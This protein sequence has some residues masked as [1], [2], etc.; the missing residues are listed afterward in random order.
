MKF[1]CKLVISLMLF[2]TLSGFLC[3]KN[4]VTVKAA[5]AAEN[6]ISVVVD[7]EEVQFDVSPTIIEG[8]TM[9]PLRA[10][11]E[12]LEARVDWN[13]DTKTVTGI[14]DNITIKLVAGSKLAEVNGKQVLLDV[15]ATIISGRTL[16]P[17]RFISEG[18]GAKVS[19]DA[20]NREVT[21]LTQDVIK[22]PDVNFEKAIRQNINK[23]SGD[24]LSS[25]LKKILLFD[26]RE[27]DISDIEGIQ[28][29]KNARTLYLEGNSITDISLL[30]NLNKL[31][32]ISL[33]KNRISDI[34]PLAQLTNLKVI[35]IHTNLIRDITPLKSL[36]NLQELYIGGNSIKNIDV[37]SSLN[38]LEKL[39]LGDNQIADMKPLASLK[40]LTEIDIYANSTLDMTPL[41]EL[42]NLKEV[43]VEYY[44]EQ[45]MLNEEFYEKYDIMQKKARDIIDRVIKPGM[46]DLE[47]ELALHDYLVFNT[48][49][50]Y[51]NYLSDSVPEESH[52][53]Y[54][55]LINKVAVCDG[56]ART[57]QILLNMVGI[58]NEF[59]YGD[60]DGE[61]GWIGHAWNIVKVDGEYYHLDVTFD[62]IDR[63]GRDIKKDSITHT[64]FNVSDRQISIDHRWERDLYPHCNTDSD[65]FTR[66]SKM[67]GNKI[68]NQDTAY[69]LD[70][71]N[72]IVKL[73]LVDYTSSRLS[74]N[75]AEKVV[76]CED[77]IYYINMSYTR[78]GSLYR[79]KTDG[80]NEELVY[81][82]EV[83]FLEEDEGNIYF[84]DGDDRINI[85]SKSETGIRKIS[86]GSIATVLYFTEDFIIYKAYKW[87]I[88][89]HFYRISKDTGE[90]ERIN[91]DMPS[92]FSY[93]KYSGYLTYYNTPL[94]RVMDDW[95][96]YANTGEGNSLFK[97]K[98]DGTERSRLNHS[99]STIIDII[100]QWLYYH[101]ES[102]G[103]KV[104]RVKTDGSENIRVQE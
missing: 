18:F 101:N 50:D 2:F 60:A 44:Y 12:A 66:V 71:E 17:A 10:I 21:I 80:S 46:T 35:Y 102:D 73:N 32:R 87:D 92:G 55:V 51:E 100:G 13:P 65:Y 57:M 77:Y 1:N 62:N 5:P 98:V 103:S 37:L 49:Y 104:Y 99:D 7:W 26:A 38:K 28:Y 9:V 96:Y 29:M 64:Y 23:Y 25:D 79:V 41:K 15:P 84:I 45:T 56:F 3:S 63:D 85:I 76:L 14:R 48:T 59:I 24:I 81:N 4:L 40:M 47:K 36:I 61:K 70:G 54:G 6:H 91:S 82:G 39:Y 34:S 75:R 90:T 19:W 88:G 16:V 74:L 8:R 20:K 95:I 31:E 33:S 86:N 93:S 68:I 42:K 83:K 22:I 30:S 53:P 52:Q 78:S 97:V 69:Y 43:Y 89:G 58:E 72:K 94:E 27:K 67:N 11:F